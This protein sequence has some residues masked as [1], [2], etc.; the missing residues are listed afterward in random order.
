MFPVEQF[1]DGR[2]ARGISAIVGLAGGHRAAWLWLRQAN[3]VLNGRTPIELLKQDRVDE[4][5]DT[6]RA[7]F[8][9]Q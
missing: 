6:A 3:P 7:Y 2:P 4:V 8:N 1:I 9:P 5:V